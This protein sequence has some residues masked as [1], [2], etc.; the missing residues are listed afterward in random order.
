MLMAAQQGMPSSAL[1]LLEEPLGMGLTD[2]GDTADAVADEGAY[3][4][5]RILPE[6]ARPPGAGVVTG[7]GAEG[8][9]FPLGAPL[10]AGGHR[11]GQDACWALRWRL[12]HRDPLIASYP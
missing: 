10:E 11:T 3:Y 8:A 9:G 1:R 12:C 5:E 4:L 7:I 6:W 2:A